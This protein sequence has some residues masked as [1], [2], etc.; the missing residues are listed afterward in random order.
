VPLLA[1]SAV[2]GLL[3]GLVTSLLLARR[4]RRNG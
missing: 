1:G 2:A 4:A 3:L